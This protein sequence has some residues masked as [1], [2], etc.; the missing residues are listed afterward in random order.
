VEF[1]PEIT[2]PILNVV[3]PRFTVDG[4]RACCAKPELELPAL[5]LTLFGLVVLPTLEIVTTTPVAVAEP[6]FLIANFITLGM[7]GIKFSV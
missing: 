4:D 6:S 3:V 2:L 7:S 5:T 1:L